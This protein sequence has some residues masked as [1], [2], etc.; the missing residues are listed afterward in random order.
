MLWCGGEDFSLTAAPVQFRLSQGIAATGGG[1]DQGVS[2]DDTFQPTLGLLYSRGRD[3]CC[4]RCRPC[5]ASAWR[6]STPRS[7]CTPSLTPSAPKTVACAAGWTRDWAAAAQQCSQNSAA[8]RC[9]A[10]TNCCIR[11]FCSP[12][13]CRLIQSTSPHLNPFAAVCHSPRLRLLRPRCARRDSPRRRPR[14]RIRRPPAR[15]PPAF[16][17]ACSPPARLRVPARLTP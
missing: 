1:P 7:A 4:C 14:L 11:Y 8:P 17:A 9:P 10:T 15:A 2:K 16:A 5:C 12:V 13:H 3:T 6:S